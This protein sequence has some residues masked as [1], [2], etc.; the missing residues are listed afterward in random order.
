MKPGAAIQSASRPKISNPWNKPKRCHQ[1]QNSVLQLT[2]ASELQHQCPTLANISMLPKKVAYANPRYQSS[3]D[4]I[5]NKYDSI[6][7]YIY[8]QPYGQPCRNSHDDD[9]S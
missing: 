9:H 8:K 5:Q 3:L 4:T 7:F 1:S 6:N 2:S